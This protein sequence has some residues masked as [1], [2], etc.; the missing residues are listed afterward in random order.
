MSDL[1]PVLGLWGIKCIIHI[2]T[3][4]TLMWRFLW[5]MY[6]FCFTSLHHE[7]ISFIFC[8]SLRVRSISEWCAP[9]T[10]TWKVFWEKQKHSLNYHLLRR[11]FKVKLRQ[12][13]P[14]NIQQ[15]SKLKLQAVCKIDWNHRTSY[16]EDIFQYVVM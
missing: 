4:A 3:K 14:R 10:W 15:I 2:I 13:Y 11:L 9:K 16:N 7:N 8:S 6:R 12:V 5:I 1:V